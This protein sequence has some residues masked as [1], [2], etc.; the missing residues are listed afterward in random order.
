MRQFAERTA[1]NTPLQGGAADLIKLAMLGVHRA[2]REAKLHARMI[3]QV[4]D[5]LIL[6][7]PEQEIA[8]TASLVRERMEQA[9]PFLVPIVA[10]VSAGPNWRDMEEVLGARC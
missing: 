8:P 2:L 6:E 5:E 9:H 7:V 4:H 10:E 1:I 3:L